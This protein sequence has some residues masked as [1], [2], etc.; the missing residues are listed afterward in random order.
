MDFA[1]SPEQSAMLDVVE[2]FVDRHLPMTDQRRRDSERDPPYELLPLL[3]ETGLLRFPFSEDIGGL[4]GDWSTVSMVQEALG[5]R[6]WMLGSLFNRAIGFGGMSLMSFGSEQQK[7]E[8]MPQLMDGRLLFALALTEDEAGSD[9]AAVRTRAELNGR[10]WQLTGRKTWISDAERA[11]YL[12]TVARSGEGQRRSDGLTLFLV[13]RGTPG[14]E[15]RPIE[16]VGNHCLPTFE[17]LLDRVELPETA[18][19]GEIGKGFAS[20]AKTLHY[21]RCGLAAATVGYAQFAVDLALTH[22]RERRQFGRPLGAHQ[23]LAHRLADMQMEVDQARLVVRELAWRID[24]GA[25][26]ARQAA[27][28]KVIATECLHEVASKAMQILASQAYHQDSDIARI[29]R[30]SRLYTF[31]EGSNEIQRNIIARELGLGDGR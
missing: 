1:V 18:V 8:L 17:V 5:R 9:A 2:R 11:D 23:A 14:V 3:A 29:W 16:K 10:T 20:L 27:Q 21:A 7:S 31:G 26:T 22:A 6:A 28:A 15:C 13:P 24:T 30:D 4:G 12:V 19:L 25:D